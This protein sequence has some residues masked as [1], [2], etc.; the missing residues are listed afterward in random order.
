MSDKKSW[1]EKLNSAK[2]HE[3][4]KAP[5]AIG[6]AKKGDK[7]LIPSP[8]IIADEIKAIPEG[9]SRDIEQLRVI[10]AA[11][12]GADVAC[13]IAMNIQLRMVAE[14]AYE[15]LGA[16][17]AI[18]EITPFWRVLDEKEPLTQKLSCGADF[19]RR[20]RAMEGVTQAAPKAID[21][22]EERRERFRSKSLWA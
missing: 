8:Q 12:F 22:D 21:E 19:V 7:L 2:P 6:G 16:G 14:A 17:V 5:M 10:L 9:E 3:V 13:P 11:K 15:S 1:V 20:R 4:T 18:A